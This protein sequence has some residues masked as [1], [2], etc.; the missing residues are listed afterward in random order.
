MRPSQVTESRLTATEQR[1]CARIAKR[2]DELIEQLRRLVAI[3]T[4]HN[5]APGLDEVRGILTQR[6]ADL[7]AQVTIV[8]G[9]P[10]PSWLL[11]GSS[12]KAPPAAV[13]A[14]LT[15]DLPKLLFVGHMD[16]VF[17][18]DG[19]FQVMN[20]ASD[21]KSA[22]GPGVVDMKGGLVTTIAALE[23]LTA[24][25][26]GAA[27][28]FVLTS[29][30]ETGSYHSEGVIREQASRH[31][32]GLIMEP[33]LPGG[34]LVVERLGSGQ[35]MVEA[36]GRSAHVGRAFE[37]GVSAVNAL[38][39]A[40]VAIAEM[41]DV[42]KGRIINIGPVQGGDA[43]NAVPAH[44]SAWGNVR[45]PSQNIADELSSMLSALE[46]TENALPRVKVHTS[47]NRPAKPMTP[48]VESLALRAREA[49]ESLGQ[50]LPFAKTGGVC[51]GNILQD[52]GLPCIDTLG[53]R[54]GG[55]HT[56]D[57]WI[58]L[59][60]LVERAQLMA[61]LVSRLSERAAG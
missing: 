1:L 6:L 50:K 26:V 16:T 7:G 51:D 10:K 30:E 22:T 58:E 33:A 52:A 44:A 20:I 13:C 12:G 5:H 42:A 14:K 9:D 61:V 47:F 39:R 40:I 57:E 2:R 56:T 46:T 59:D 38:A 36:F 11:G 53:V 17:A 49:A 43:T 54:G 34:E 25:G 15:P 41:P 24:E 21:G 23:A 37:T 8:P 27:W 18:P 32:L 19:A 29:D 48:D 3:P 60:S 35:F 55:L 31:D 45:Y 28:T 4:G